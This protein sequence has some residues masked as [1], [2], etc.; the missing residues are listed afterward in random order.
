MCQIMTRNVT[1]LHDPDI[2]WLQFRLLRRRKSAV[3]AT[4]NFPLVQRNG[5]VMKIETNKCTLSKQLHT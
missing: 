1:S 3:L 2:F 5:S 4:L